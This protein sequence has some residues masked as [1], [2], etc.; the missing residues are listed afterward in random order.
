MRVHI[1]Y[2]YDSRVVG[3]VVVEIVVVV[4]A[5]IPVVVVVVA[6]SLP[7][8][9]HVVTTTITIAAY[10]GTTIRFVGHCGTSRLTFT[11]PHYH[12]TGQS[13]AAENAPISRQRRA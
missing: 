8:N 9:C 11:R 3:L 4:V 7:C 6:M 10:N 2:A 13:V 5:V 12:P 1:T